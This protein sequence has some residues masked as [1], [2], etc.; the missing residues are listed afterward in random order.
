MTSNSSRILGE[1]DWGKP[2]LRLLDQSKNLKREAPASLLI[3]HSERN[4][5]EKASEM[6][7]A[8]LTDRGRDA[9]YNFGQLLPSPWELRIIHSPVNRCKE[10]ATRIHEGSVSAGLKSEVVGEL[11]LLW[12]PEAEWDIFSQLLIRDW[13]LSY[14]HWMSGRYSPS[15]VEPSIEYA[16]RLADEFDKNSVRDMLTIYVAH[17]TQIITLLFHWFGIPPK[18]ESASFLNGFFVQKVDGKLVL[19]SGDTKSECEAPHWWRANT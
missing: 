4:K 7:L 5:I 17:D 10:T 3:R 14:S 19:L 15:V 13:P 11:K 16:K 6:Q 1:V 8:G 12:G 9:A 18:M 2:V